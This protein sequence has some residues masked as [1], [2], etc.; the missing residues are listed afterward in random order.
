MRRIGVAV[1]LKIK[2]N[3]D[4][5][6]LEKFGFVP[7][8]STDTGKL[9]EMFCVRELP[10]SFW[11]RCFGKCGITLKNGNYKVKRTVIYNGNVKKCWLIDNND[12]FD[13]FDTD[14]LYDLIQAGY[15]EK[16]EE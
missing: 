8:Y 12:I 9:V 2:D 3:V 7:R 11:T 15:V 5:K 6:E 10:N 16:V 14:T 4:L 1:M 13:R